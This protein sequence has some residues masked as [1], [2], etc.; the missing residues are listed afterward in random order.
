MF[1]KLWNTLKFLII[2]AIVLICL[3]HSILP[4]Q[5]KSEGVDEI[6]N[7]LKANESETRLNEYKDSEEVIRMKLTQLE[8]INSSRKKNRASALKLDILAS[9]VA[10]KISREAA[11]NDY[12]GHWNMAG[13]KP[14]HRYA[15]AG[16]HDHISENAF[17]ESSS[18]NYVNSST[19]IG[20]LLKS[21][22]NSFMSEKPPYDGHKKNVIAKEHNYVGIGYCLSG[23]QFRYYEEYL[24]RYL[25][26]DNIPSE[27][28]TSEQ[29]TI[30]LKTDGKTFLYYLIVYRDNFPSPLTPQQIRRKGSYTDYGDEEYLSMP[31]WELSRFR[32]GPSYVIPLVF[33]KEGLYYVQVYTDS[34][35]ITR[36]G[37][38]N[39]KGKSPVSGIVIRVKNQV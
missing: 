13:E 12:T 30:T 10:N 11:E 25:E 18:V 6:S 4:R 38:I 8:I 34:K 16:G 15:F 39:T 29:A 28:K 36:S 22:H 32:N 31:A 9:R 14:Y 26:F 2:I 23:K 3:P 7:Y 24:D 20:E 37:S 35:E 33:K 5:T 19:K 27:T 21:A 1:R 17:G